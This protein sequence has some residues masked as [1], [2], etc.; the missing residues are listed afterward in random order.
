[1]ACD[2]SAFQPF[3]TDTVS[4]DT[5]RGAGFRRN[6]TV[7]IPRI[8]TFEPD[9]PWW[10]VTEAADSITEAQEYPLRSARTVPKRPEQ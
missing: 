2:S 7:V 9:T 6:I 1:M 10:V 5:Q 8:G 3:V 4:E